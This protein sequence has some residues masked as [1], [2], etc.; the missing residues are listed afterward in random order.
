VG[1]YNNE[2]KN[3]TTNEWMRDRYYFYAP[4]D[5][6]GLIIHNDARFFGSIGNDTPYDVL[7]YAEDSHIKLINDY[8]KGAHSKAWDN[9]KKRF[10]IVF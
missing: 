1:I 9:D 4:I 5:S 10:K 3:E 2:V 6:N 7:A 8:L